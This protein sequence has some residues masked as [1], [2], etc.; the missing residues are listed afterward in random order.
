VDLLVRE[1]QAV[2]PDRP[3]DVPAAG[4]ALAEE[5]L[6][7][8]MVTT[9][10]VDPDPAARRLLE[11]CAE[12][13]ARLVRLGFYRYHAEVGY[14]R[15]LQDAR[16]RLEGFA[17]LAQRL[18]LTL[19]VQL[20]HGTIHS[21]GALTAA[22]VHELPPHLVGAYADPGNQVKEGSEDWR[23][24]LDLLG[25]R[26]HCIGVK[27]AA[28]VPAGTGTAGQR[29]WQ[30]GWVPLPQGQAPWPEILSDLVGRGYRG[31]LTFHAPY[32]GSLTE[33]L[34]RAADDLAFVRGLLPAPTAELVS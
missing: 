34:Q 8:K 9:D 12:A 32:Q 20:H 11:A 21:S 5:G 3:A 26:L 19:L 7:L 25:G 28:W 14:A 29:L 10:L 23:L 31:L 33:V 15:C 27:N 22:L 18:G 4:R 1:G 13:G 17:A 16:G 24:T 2:R 6:T 30:A